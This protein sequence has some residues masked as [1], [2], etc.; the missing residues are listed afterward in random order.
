MCPRL[1]VDG[2]KV[3]EHRVTLGAYEREQ[4]DTMVTGVTV[5]NITQPFVSLI[6]D[7]SAMLV[8]AGILEALGIIDISGLAKKLSGQG[9]AW[10][11]EVL[12]GAFATLDAAMLAWE[13][14]FWD[15]YNI[16]GG[17]LPGGEPW[18][19]PYVPPEEYTLSTS[20]RTWAMIQIYQQQA[21]VTQPAYP[22]AEPY[23]GVP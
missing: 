16:G 14:R 6:S 18:I 9:Q 10:I 20:D 19:D 13:K 21:A 11:E 12:S 15:L 17:I 8:I 22:G 7:A 4:L 5:K 23:G 2:K 3:V 1:P